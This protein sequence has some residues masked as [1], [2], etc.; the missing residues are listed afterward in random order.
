MCMPFQNHGHIYKNTMIYNDD[1]HQLDQSKV[2]DVNVETLINQYSAVLIN[3]DLQQPYKPTILW[4]LMQQHYY[5]KS[6]EIFSLSSKMSSQRP[7]LQWLNHFSSCHVQ[8]LKVFLVEFLSF[9]VMFQFLSL[10]F[11]D[12]S[13][14]MMQ[15]YP[16]TLHIT[17]GTIIP[18]IALPFLTFKEIFNR[19]CL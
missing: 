11:F 15:S 4:S 19:K 5:G 17:F 10:Q 8:Y 2:F 9:D 14:D 6:V 16:S 13:L 12:M 18:C 7:C 1:I 3:I